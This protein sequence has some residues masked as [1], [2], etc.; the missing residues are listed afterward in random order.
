MSAARTSA[1]VIGREDLNPRWILLYA[2]TWLLQC[3]SAVARYFVLYAVIWVPDKIEYLDL[4]VKNLAI[5]I[6]V[7]PL[8]IS[9][10]TLVLP[11]GGWLWEQQEGARTPSER[12]Q[13]VFDFAFAELTEK[14]PLPLRPPH[15]W[16][17]LDESE[18]N[19]CVY[20]ITLMLTRGLLDSPFGPAVLGHEMRHLNS[21]D[22]QTSG[23][24][25][26]HPL[27]APQPD[28]PRVQGTRLRIQRTGRDAS[29]EDRL[30]DV[31]PRQG[32]ERRQLRQGTRSRT[33]ARGLPRD[34]RPG[35]RPPD[36]IQDVRRLLPPL[37]RA[38]HR[39]NL[40]AP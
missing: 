19:G 32:D 14:D 3:I 15:R 39:P 1:Y 26:S 36:S 16:C 40:L 37:D 35:G 25:V 20:A 30:V 28:P 13:A 18:P 10:A 12:E 31:L 7:A 24:P 33:Y 5:V 21:G 4:P 8:L 9:L 6:A 11:W 34:P 38:P 23:G 29:R 27:L 2:V 17:V 22:G